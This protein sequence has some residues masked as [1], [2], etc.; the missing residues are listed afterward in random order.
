MHGA[1][2]LDALRRRDPALRCMGMGGPHLRE[3]GLE[4]FFRTE[5]LSVMGITEVMGQ[6]PRILRLLSGI[7]RTLREEKP[8]AAVVIDAPDFHFRVIRAARS[9]G[10]PVYYYISP[11]IWAWRQGRVRF[12]RENVRTVLSILPF[13]QE[14]YRRF[15]MEVEYVGNPLLDE[16]DPERYA[17]APEPGLIGLLPGSRKK[18]V[19]ALLREFAGAAR[20][21]RRRFPELAFVC[22]RAP[23]MDAGLLRTLWP[24]DV[25]VDFI[26]PE[27]RWNVMRRCEMLMAASGTVTLESAV[28]GVPT[29][30][31]YRVSPLSYALGRI[32]LHVPFISLPN[33]ILGRAV[34]PE[35]LQ[36][37]CNAASLAEAA[38]R[39]LRP[40]PEERPLD[41]VRRDL[42]EVRR[43]LGEPGAA[44]RAAGIILR[45]LDR[46][47]GK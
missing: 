38:L 31:A 1:R 16:I 19:S 33:L 3:A 17:A 14:F 43:R 29:I 20:I 6:L 5:D 35:L 44:D 18:E 4:A 41:A 34:F 22:P 26:A 45:D 23:G 2:L 47:R 30:V 40:P 46:I 42:E 27:E 10:I 25:P 21:L 15:G 28:L 37:R 8:A 13:E 11:K 12:I 36:E 7:T 9:L 39:W 32:L 24:D